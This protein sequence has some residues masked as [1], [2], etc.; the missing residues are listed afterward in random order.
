MPDHYVRT[1]VPHP[2]QRGFI[3]S[4]AKRKIIRAGRRGGKTTG[5]AIYAVKRFM[6]KR[7]VLY[8]VPT[9]DQ[10][11]RFWHEIKMALQE[12]IDAGLVYKNET[13][14]LIEFPGTEQRIRAK[15]AWNADTLRGDYADDLILDEFQLMNETTWSEVGVPMLLD[16][17]GDAVFIYTPPSL[18]NQT[19][20][21]AID[22][23]HAAKMFKKAE[24]DTTGRWE[25]FHFSS[26][27]NPYISR[28]A[29][30]EITED[31]TAMGYQAEIEALDID[32]IPGALWTREMIEKHREKAPRNEAGQY[33]LPR[34]VIGVDPSVGKGTGAECGIVPV[35]RSATRHAYVLD[36]CTVS[37]LPEVWAAA[38]VN[39]YHDHEADAIIAEANNGGEMVRSTIKSIDP[40]VNVIIVHATRGKIPRAE[41]VSARAS[42][43]EI[44]H[45]GVFPMLEDQLCTYVPGMDSPDRFDAM[46]WAV[47]DLLLQSKGPLKKVK[48]KGI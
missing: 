36:D 25:T 45:D 21:K 18:S 34:I 17:N 12:L 41:P 23:R 40:S 8:G 10:V 33:L 15:T 3:D 27:D 20:S 11:D 48:V 47:T 46:V 13:L 39:A 29:L 44:H 24:K 37:G 30:D 26:H 1:R 32:E 2:K 42:R 5:I 9:Q 16:N 19:L 43:G 14:H 4:T 7:R 35:G 22:P 31:M 6:R 38:A 28:D